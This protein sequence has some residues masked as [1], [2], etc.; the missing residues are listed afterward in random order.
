[1]LTLLLATLSAGAHCDTW[2][3]PVVTDARA[4]LEKGVATPVLKWVP[5]E[6][7]AEVREAFRKAVAARGAGPAAKD[8]ADQWFFETVVRLHRAGEG[9]P[10]TG[11]KPP[12]TPV[13]PLIAR[14]DAALASG[15][16]ADL[17]STVTHHVQQELQAR[18]ARVRSAAERKDQS[19]EA[20]RAWV[21]AYV[22]YMDL[23]E[24]V[25]A[26]LESGHGEP[27]TH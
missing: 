20:G 3:G 14:A 7:E 21:E 16:V 23:V 10:F 6:S 22:S 11:L 4:A 18:Y 1:M 8:L 24:A 5:A 9:M 13:D 19:V 15:K 25:E 26:G 12:G 17:S 27:A 2:E